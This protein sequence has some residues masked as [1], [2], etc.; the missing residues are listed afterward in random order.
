[1]EPARSFLPYRPMGTAQRSSWH[2]L[3]LQKQGGR[4]AR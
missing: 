4:A 2:E 3:L 1:M